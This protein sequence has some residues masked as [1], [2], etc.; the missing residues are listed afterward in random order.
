M[1]LTEGPGMGET[2]VDTGPT[3]T[4]SKDGGINVDAGLIPTL[5]K[6]VG[7]NASAGAGMIGTGRAMWLC[8]ASTRDVGPESSTGPVSTCRGPV[9]VS[10]GDG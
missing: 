1:L 4:L 6:G 10:T 9:S 8:V 2:T 3:P 7:I 5:S